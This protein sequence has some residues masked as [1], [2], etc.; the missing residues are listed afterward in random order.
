MSQPYAEGF[1]YNEEYPKY[2]RATFG[3]Q[4]TDTRERVDMERMRKE[5]L[6]QARKHMKDAGISV[7]LLLQNANMR[8]T[9]GYTWLGY[10]A[11]GAYVL[12]PL[13]GEPM[14]FS[15]L[16]TAIQDRRGMPWIKPEYIRHWLGGPGSSVKFMDPAAFELVA[17]RTARQI[18]GALEEL[19]MAKELLTLDVGSDIVPFL[20]KEGIKTAV[21]AETMVRAQEIKTKD[22]I[23]CFRVTAAICDLIHYELSKYADAGKTERECAGYMNY[24]AM[25]YGS[26]PGPNCIFVSGQ[27]TWPNLVYPT[28]KMLMPGDLFYC[29]TVTVGW[30]GYKSCEYRSYSCVTPPSQAAKDAAKRLADRVYGSLQDCKAGNTTADILKHWPKERTFVEGGQTIEGISGAIHGLGLQSYGP[31]YG[32][33]HF[34]L[35]HPYPLKEGH[36]FAIETDEPVGDGQGVRLEDMVVVT[37]TGCEILTHATAEITTCPVR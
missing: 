26:E 4:M 7:M 12:L 10:A 33:V 23:E 18:K 6:A 20:Q 1:L 27:H 29:D 24:I 9:T 11:G 21:N 8:Y 28:D 14:V 16:H 3:L 13:Q 22:E 31:P 30:N 34:S 25:K 19:G 37:K 5:R 15:H 17:S 32:R 2:A 35:E 36:V